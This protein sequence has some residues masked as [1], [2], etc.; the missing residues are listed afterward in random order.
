MTSIKAMSCFGPA[1]GAHNQATWGILEEKDK[2]ATD[3]L[4][5]V[6]TANEG[7][8]GLKAQ[9]NDILAPYEW[10]G[11]LAK[12]VLDRLVETPNDRP[13][14]GAI[15]KR[16]FYKASS[17]ASKNLSEFNFCKVAPAMTVAIGILAQVAPLAV[18][19]LGFGE[20]GRVVEGKLFAI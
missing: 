8:E 4:H 20:N 10:Y 5:I 9:I 7:G 1:F 15:A 14:M 17:T 13:Q 2:L 6:F 3:V 12:T 11:G 19:A 16:A 18:E